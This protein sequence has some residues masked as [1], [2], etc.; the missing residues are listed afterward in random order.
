MKIGRM[1]NIKTAGKPGR[2]KASGKSNRSRAKERINFIR[3]WWAIRG[4]AAGVLIL[5][6]IYGGY[7]GVAKVIALPSL[8]VKTIR[9]EGCRKIESGNVVQLSG[10]H[11]GEPLLRMDLKE[12]RRRVIQHPVIKDAAV[13]RE[14][15]CTL[16]ITVEERVPAAAVMNGDFALVD[17]E[18]VVLSSGASYT[19]K[20]PI[21]TGTNTLPAPGKVAVEAL[22]ALGALGKLITSGLMGADRISELRA[23][24]RNV[25]VSLTDS[26]TLLVLPHEGIQAALDRLARLMESGIFDVGAPG[27][28]LRFEKRVVV[29]PERSGSG[30][31]EGSISSAGG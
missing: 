3:I 31:W 18:G 16:R 25:L 4:V 17:M 28:D 27:Y 12:I 9:V 10:V 5:T 11:L 19:D 13:V 23:N 6:F 14:L 20:Y 2:K 21:I 8:A 29:M 22:P 1:K 7:L 26:G 15:P 30:R 24:G